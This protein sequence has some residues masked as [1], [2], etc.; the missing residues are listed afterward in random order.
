MSGMRPSLLVVAFMLSGCVSHYPTDLSLVSVQAVNERDQ[1]ELD[2]AFQSALTSPHYVMR[3]KVNL[4]KSTGNDSLTQKDLDDYYS[5]ISKWGEY[6]YES[7]SHKTAI[8]HWRNERL[9]ELILRIEFQSKENLQEYVRGHHYHLGA[10]AYFCERRDGF[11][12][13]WGSWDVFWRGF[14]LSKLFL[15]TIPRVSETH[16]MTYYVF[17]DA[18]LDRPKSVDAYGRPFPTPYDLRKTAEDV[19]LQ[20]KGGVFGFG[21]KSNVVKIP[22]QAIAEAFKTLPPPFDTT[23]VPGAVTQTK[24]ECLEEGSSSP[25]QS[26]A[27]PNGPPV[28]PFYSIRSDCRSGVRD[29]AA[30]D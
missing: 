26:T 23:T 22:R 11:H 16:P 5:M 29:P 14:N 8:K 13:L 24:P 4:R 3:Y 6:V 2:S 28:P 20:V 17:V 30:G 25:S 18:R 27:V 12:D 10:R 15:D 19:C 7:E 21:Y 1:M 9:D